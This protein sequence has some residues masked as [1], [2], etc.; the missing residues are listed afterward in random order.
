MGVHIGPNILFSLFPVLL[1]PLSL[2]GNFQLCKRQ[3]Q[4]NITRWGCRPG[5]VLVF[6][7]SRLLDGV[8]IFF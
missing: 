5:S 8:G 7:L 6:I 1:S 2:R 3:K 4:K